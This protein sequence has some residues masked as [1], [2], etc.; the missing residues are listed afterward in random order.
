MSEGD[1]R[2]WV[3]LARRSFTG[4]GASLKPMAVRLSANEWLG[5]RVQ[6]REALGKVLRRYSI[7]RLGI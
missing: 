6:H 2:H 1:W 4:L 5:P 3:T 7:N